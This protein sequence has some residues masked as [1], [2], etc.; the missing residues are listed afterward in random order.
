MKTPRLALAMGYIDDKLV[1][2]AIE[3]KHQPIKK[4]Y[5]ITWKRWIAFAA[6][7]CIVVSGTITMYL[8]EQQGV[9][10]NDNEPQ[11]NLS[12]SEAQAY[13]PFGTYFPK[14]IIEGYYLETEVHIF[15]GEVLSAVFI[16]DSTGDSLELRIATRSRFGDIETG[17][18]FYRPNSNSS[19][20]YIDCGEYI[21]YY[22]SSQCDLNKLMGF[23]MMVYSADYYSE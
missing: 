16:N 2:G 11:I 4:W 17:T 5:Q 1:S 18:V 7:L 23:E 12:L 14:V 13:K 22:S 8:I 19:Y 15:D 6:C 20:I 9:P 3:Y 10:V 21:A